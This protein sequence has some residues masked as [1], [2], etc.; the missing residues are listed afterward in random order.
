MPV[1]EPLHVEHGRGPCSVTSSANGK[2]CSA[3]QS[4]HGFAAAEWM[5][6]HAQTFYLDAFISDL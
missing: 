6:E 4:L 5:D 3:H 2:P 1:D